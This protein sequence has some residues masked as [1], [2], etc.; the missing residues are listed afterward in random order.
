MSRLETL[1][2][3]KEPN[4]FDNKFAD[5][6]TKLYNQTLNK[7]KDENE[8][9]SKNYQKLSENRESLIERNKELSYNL[10]SKFV[11]AYLANKHFDFIFKD[12]ESIWK[13][14]FENWIKS[15]DIQLMLKSISNNKELSAMFNKLD[16]QYSLE[17]GYN[18]LTEE[19]KKTFIRNINKG[20]SSANMLAAVMLLNVLNQ[21][22]AEDIQSNSSS[23]NDFNDF[24]NFGGFGGSSGGGGATSSW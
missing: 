15:V 20:D 16:N 4:E 17:D 19:Q 14:R 6:N 5:V 7:L 22:Q 12:Y 24:N 23:S 10:Y 11:Y 18:N 21:M 9:N 13:Q 3:A 8:I 2:N 1:D